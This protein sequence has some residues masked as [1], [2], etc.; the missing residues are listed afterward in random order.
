MKMKRNNF[1]RVFAEILHPIVFLLFRIKL[2]GLENLPKDRGFVFCSNHISFADPAFWLI[3]TKRRIFYMAKEEVFKNRFARW[4][5]SKCDVFTVKRGSADISSINEA[6]SIVK[7]GGI[8][9][10]FPEGTRSKDGEPQRAKSGA[11]YIANA[12]NADIVPAAI[13]CKGKVRPFKKIKLVIGKPILHNE[14]ELT[15]NKKSSLRAVS[16]RIMDEISK[17]RE[18]YL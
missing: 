8:L 10:I 12:A 7:R 15:E 5:Y 16:S 9:G 2:I 4:F 18:Q 1:V 3:Y 13:V 14:I 17:L 11:A 6:F